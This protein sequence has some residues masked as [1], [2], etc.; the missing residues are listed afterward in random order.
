MEAIHLLK[1]LLDKD[2]TMRPSAAQVLAHPWM[3]VGASNNKKETPLEDAAEN[4]RK[5]VVSW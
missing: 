2:P 4:L 5:V 1:Q 3:A